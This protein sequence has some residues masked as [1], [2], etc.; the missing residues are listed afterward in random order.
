MGVKLSGSIGNRLTIDEP[1]MPGLAT[2]AAIT[3]TV[4]EP[5]VDV[6][7]VYRPVGVIVPK[8]AGT[9]DQVTAG[10]LVPGMSAANCSDW[11]SARFAVCGRT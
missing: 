4:V 8:F 3:V 6:G 9:I 2:L 5:V 7:A 11:R 1:E 10:L